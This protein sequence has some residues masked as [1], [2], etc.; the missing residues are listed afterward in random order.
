MVCFP[1]CKIN[2]GLSIREKRSDGFH[3]LETVFY[4]LSLCDALEIV[5]AQDGKFEFTS[6]GINIPGSAKDN[7]CVKAYSLLAKRYN[8]P[9][10]KIHLHKNIPMGAGLGGGSADAAYV[11]IMINDLFKLTLN[12]YQLEEYAGNLGSDCAFFVRNTP[13]F[14]YGRGDRLRNIDLDLS[15]YHIVLVKPDI[16][17]STAEAYAGITP[18]GD[19]P[20]V[21]DLI[22][23]PIHQWKDKL[24]NDFEDHI[25]NIEPQIGEIKKDMYDNGAIYAA[26]SGSGS[27]VFGIFEKGIDLSSNYKDC[28]YWEG[29]L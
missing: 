13:C 12:Q 14:A 29:K 3:N 6:S 15:S 16:H 24:K 28:F 18:K 19:V 20:S 9:E 5:E 23:M 7:L 22:K 17:I 2:L 26:M 27:S 8:L 21:D 10:I 1:N 4:P 11:L 25:F